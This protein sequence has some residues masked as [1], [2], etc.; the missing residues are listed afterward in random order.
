MLLALAAALLALLAPAH[1]RYPYEACATM[2]IARKSPNIVPAG[3]TK[4]PEGFLTVSVNVP[5]VCN[6]RTLVGLKVKACALKVPPSVDG[7]YWDHTV[8]DFS[9]PTGG[10]VTVDAY[11][12]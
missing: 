7:S 12:V 11:C 6:G 3:Y 4:I 1:A 10:D 9:E 5:N 2:V 8:V